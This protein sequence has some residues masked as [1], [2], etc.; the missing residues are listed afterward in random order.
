MLVSLLCFPPLQHKMAAFGVPRMGAKRWHLRDTLIN[1]RETSMYRLIPLVFVFISQCL[2]AAACETR[3]EYFIENAMTRVWK[4]TIC[5]NHKL[6]FHIH[7]R[8]RVLIP[9]EDGSL[10]IIYRSGKT[11]LLKFQKQTPIYFTA[12]EGKESHQ[13]LNVGKKPLHFTVIELRKD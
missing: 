5:P 3:R 7:Q 10:Q 1:R 2:F 4:T 11:N 8:A 9:E 12:A 13:D 6:P